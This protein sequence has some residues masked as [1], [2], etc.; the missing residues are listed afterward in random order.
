MKRSRFLVQTSSLSVAA[1]FPR[2]VMADVGALR[3]SMIPE[4]ATTADSY[5]LKQPLV[6][7]LS[8]ATGLTVNLTIPI[9]YAAVVEAMGADKLDLA[10]FGGLTYCQ[11]HERYAARPLVQRTI[12]T[13]FRSLFITQGDNK[14]INSLADVAGKTFAYGDVNSTSGHLMPAY[15]LLQ[16]HVDPDTGP[17]KVIYTGNHTATALAVA[18]GK[19]DAGAMDETVYNTMLADGKAAAGALRV[20]YT[21]PPF[22]DYCWATSSSLDPAVAKKISN[23]F[24]SLD[25]SR[26]ADKDV[27]DLLRAQKYVVADD[28]NYAVLKSIARKLGLL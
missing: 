20:F 12:D 8:R 17:S 18:S 28:K 5:R 3:V 14:T 10:Y 15:N 23:A 7:M 4:V 13:S 2:L 27:L 16:A 9:N 26:P 11:A 6:D 25:P 24:L 22:Y 19:V 1:L 21:T